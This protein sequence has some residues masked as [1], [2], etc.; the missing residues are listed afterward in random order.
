MVQ[1]GD[2]ARPA[3]QVGYLPVPPSVVSRRYVR[4]LD[5]SFKDAWLPQARALGASLDDL[6]LNP[7]GAPKGP[8]VSS[9]T[10]VWRR[11]LFLIV[12]L[13]EYQ[14]AP[15]PVLEAA[16]AIAA[17]PD[18]Y[19][20]Q[21]RTGVYY[22]GLGEQ[23]PGGAAQAVTQLPG[24]RVT[25]LGNP[26]P[27]AIA[28]VSRS[29]STAA[30]TPDPDTDQGLNPLP[31]L[32]PSVYGTGSAPLAS[33][34]ADDIRESWVKY[35]MTGQ[36]S[37][38]S[39]SWPGQIEWWT[40]PVSPPSPALYLIETYRTTLVPRGSGAG[41]LRRARSVM[42]SG[43]ADMPSPPDGTAAA[44]SLADGFTFGAGSSLVRL[45]RQTELTGQ[46]I[47][48]RNLL[49]PD[50][51]HRSGWAWALSD[52]DPADRF[53]LNSSRSSYA[54]LLLACLRD[55][56]DEANLWQR[57]LSGRAA[58]TMSTSTQTATTTTSTA[59]TD[60]L[61]NLN[62]RRTLDFLFAE[63]NEAF[64]VSVA[65][66]DIR[67][68]FSN[69][70]LMSWSEAP[71]TRL[72]AFLAQLVSSPQLE[73]LGRNVLEIAASVYDVAGQ[74]VSTL[75]AVKYGDSISYNYA[76]P[77]VG[78]DWP[79]VHVW[80]ITNKEGD[81][82]P[83]VPLATGEALLRGRSRVADTRLGE[84]DALDKY[85]LAVQ[86]ADAAD[87]DLRNT[88]MQV[89]LDAL[90]AVAADDRLKAI[91]ALEKPDSALHIDLSGE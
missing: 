31:G 34:L 8:P 84:L 74:H 27:Q 59:P 52:A 40:Y 62:G 57:E 73:T 53:S 41:S 80:R 75:A 81:E 44:G 38:P 49:A 67:V 32:F 68:G 33:A 18:A 85:A 3:F 69:G 37:L 77:R 15:F 39:I 7:K 56:L 14:C 89:R 51:A 83:S 90:G 23:P 20:G 45:F 65:L 48:L 60:S 66:E 17:D 30:Y 10:D 9:L 11:F 5:D 63:L 4:L 35:T 82:L 21:L 58:S 2:V 78:V 55:H 13:L 22:P 36:L 46:S 70:R 71:L 16:R 43:T 64:E 79:E 50:L 54:R 86:D 25:R 47:A 6:G 91:S 1:I 72:P 61:S 87:K 88:E 28:A 24:G 26:A 29:A 76:G 12:D 42:P 19:Y